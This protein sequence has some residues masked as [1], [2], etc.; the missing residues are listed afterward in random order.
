[1][2]GC[3][4]RGHEEDELGGRYPPIEKSPSDRDVS[5]SNEDDSRSMPRGTRLESNRP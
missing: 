2:R 4:R 3:A 1:M 5:E